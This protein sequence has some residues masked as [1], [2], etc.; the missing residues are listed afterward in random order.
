MTLFRYHGIN[1]SGKIRTGILDAESI[2]NAHKLLQEIR[3]KAFRINEIHSTRG[4]IFRLTSSQN[5]LRL[6]QLTSFLFQL[7]LLTSSGTTLPEALTSI[8]Q[9]E[10]TSTLLQQTVLSI[11][12]RLL[13]GAP[14]SAA[15]STIPSPHASFISRIVAAAEES[16]TLPDALTELHS[17]FE[18]KLSFRN[19]LFSL[20]A[21]PALTAIIA[22][23]VIFFLFGNI[24]PTLEDVYA[25]QHTQL[26]LITR[27][28]LQLGKLS[29]PI[30]L[31]AI[32]TSV[33]FAF[34][35]RKSSPGT[36]H[37][38]WDDWKL[39]I[40][41]L[42][43][44]IRDLALSRFALGMQNLLHNGVPAVEALR[45]STQLIENH[46]LELHMNNAIQQIE[47]GDSFNT[48]MNSLSFL[49]P[50]CKQALH[51]GDRSGKL[52]DGFKRIANYLLDKT[53]RNSTTLLAL[54]EPVLILLLSTF[55]AIIVLSVLLPIFEMSE[56]I[57]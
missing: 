11:Y 3:I 51:A 10:N 56:L 57:G 46:S 16:G 22:A 41:L 25:Q 24:I 53:E 5:Q 6:A 14:P 18:K 55:V 38:K 30:L 34:W 32:L 29:L 48:A 52:D 23:V 12:G 47:N 49:P 36:L 45:L 35:L 4:L 2:E 37:Q 9:E 1:E 43:T 40:P 7:K 54:L 15:F 50:I 28:I 31:L 8:Q 13:A 33:L 26:P 20:L 19:R 44:L 17:L 21:Y 42:G 39:R 27:L